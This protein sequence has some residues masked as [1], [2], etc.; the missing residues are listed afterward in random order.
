[1]RRRFWVALVLLAA[2]A[3]AGMAMAW[4]P[5]EP[6]YQGRSM[7]LWLIDLSSGEQQKREQAVEAVQA[8]GTNALPRL[9]RML[10]A[11]DDA[12]WKQALL[13]LESKQSLLRTHF[14]PAEEVRGRAVAGFFALGSSAQ[15][16][17]V[18]ALIRIVE[19]ES[20]PLVRAYAAV[21]LG[22]IGPAAKAAVPALVKAT[23]DKNP[24]LIKSARLALANISMATPDSLR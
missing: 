20:S 22:H 7:S 4:W 5:S 3:L 9:T 19:N 21:I 8:M 12:R 16:S 2:I 11:K 15:K 6:S 10:C 14:T 13:K 1:M 24:D 18:P 17:A 23:Q